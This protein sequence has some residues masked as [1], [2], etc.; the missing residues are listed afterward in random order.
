MAK[1]KKNSHEK[2]SA[3][4]GGFLGGLGA[5]LEKL[6]ELAEQGGEIHRSGELQGLD[7][8]G[9]LRGMYGVT[10]R[11]GMGGE[12]GIKVEPFGN[13]RKD[14][15]TGRTVV[16]PVREPAVDVFEEADHILIVAE[17]PGVDPEDVRLELHED[18]LV[19]AAEKGDKKYH[20]EVLLPAASTREKM[21]YMCRNGVL[22][23]KLAK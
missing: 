10:I 22:E 18:V 17:I 2:R 12:P 23:V 8:E 4:L 5:L 9:K 21:S 20:K 11:T 1:D 15:R 14:D 19:L 7:P 6:G 16:H 13:V 3:G